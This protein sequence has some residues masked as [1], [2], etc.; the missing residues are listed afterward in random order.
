MV[1]WPTI[2]LKV[3]VNEGIDTPCIPSNF[4]SKPETTLFF[5]F[6][7]N[8]LKARPFVNVLPNAQHKHM[9]FTYVAGSKL[10]ES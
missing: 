10:M 7:V 2:H 4:H 8:S 5:P 3:A 6:S 1:R 9:C